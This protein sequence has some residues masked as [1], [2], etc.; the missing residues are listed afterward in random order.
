MSHAGIEV[1]LIDWDCISERAHLVKKHCVL[2]PS[3]TMLPWFICLGSDI[4][5]RVLDTLMYAKL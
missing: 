2:S 5:K 3:K 1:M 4:F